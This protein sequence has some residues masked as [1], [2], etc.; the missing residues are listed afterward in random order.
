MPPKALAVQFGNGEIYFSGVRRQKGS[1]LGGIFGAI[2]KYLI[3]IAR[4]YI[5]PHIIPAVKNVIQD[6]IEKK[7]IKSS[8]KKHGLNALKDIGVKVFTQKGSGR[9]RR[10]KTTKK[11]STKSRIKKRVIKR[12]V[13]KR[14]LKRKIKT[15]KLRYLF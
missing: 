4:D 6:K 3:P 5:I 7:D 9:R 13:R 10:R 11:A 1:G 12:K 14:A 8:V 15:N 2:G